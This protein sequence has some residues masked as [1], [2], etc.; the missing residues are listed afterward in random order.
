[1][2][3]LS[4]LFV[5]IS[6]EICH[7]ETGLK[8]RVLDEQGLPLPYASVLV[9][10]LNK[11]TSTNLDGYFFVKLENGS[12]TVHISS[13]GYQTLTL[14]FS[15]GPEL[16]DMGE[17]HL[18][19]AP[20][21]M[22][23]FV[24]SGSRIPEK[25][26][27]APA[28][29]D[30]IDGRQFEKFT[31]SPDELFALQKGVDFT[32]IG[33]F[34]ASMNVR[35]FNNAF[36]QKM[37]LLDDNRIA[38]VRIRTPVGPM[39]PYVKEDIERVELVLGPSSALYGPNCLNGLF[40]TISK[41]PFDRPGTDVVVG[42]GSN[43]L[44]NVR[45][46][47]A[48]KL[49]SKWAYK[50]TFE[51]LSGV[52]EEDYTDS[53]YIL[54]G[55]PPTVLRGYPEVGLDRDLLFLKGLAGVYY[56]PTEKS[57]L[58]INYTFTRNNSISVGNRNNLVDWYNASLQA[59]YKS[60]HWFVQFYKTWIN[61]GTS[62]NTV[63]RTTNYYQLL[64]SQTPDEAFN[65]SLNAPYAATFEDDTY[66][67]NGEIQYNNNWGNWSVTAGSQ[68]Q[69]EVAA[70][71]NTLYIGEPVRSNMLGVYGQ[72]MY[73]IAETGLKLLATA[74]GDDHSL[75]GFNFVP[76]A[77]ITY[78][79]N[80]ST[81]RLTYGEGSANPT[82]INS[83]I[84]L[85]VATGTTLGNSEG[86]TRSDGSKVAP[87]KPETLQTL[88]VGYKNIFY[89]R[90]LFVDIDAYYNWASN[91]I[92][93]V[94]SITTIGGPAIT[95]RGD[96]PIEDFVPP[97]TPIS[98]YINYGRANTYGLDIGLNYYLTD[99]YSL[100]LN[101]SFFEYIIDRSDANND[102][103]KD[104]IVNSQDIAPNTPENKISAA[105]NVKHNKFYGSL[106][107]RWIQK[108]DFFSG[109]SVA[110]STNPE[111]TYFLSPVVEGQR[112]GRSWNYG[113][114]GGFYL[115]F[116]GNYQITRRLNFG[117]YVNNILGQGNYEFVAA[118]ATETTFGAEIKVSF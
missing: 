49:S 117:L 40:N 18:I 58:G 104:G 4:F 110:A 29:I 82:L 53:V 39:S 86:F 109:R 87:I 54:T 57:E 17:I 38:N 97:K 114:L 34:M 108:Y 59:T 62:T 48:R 69:R 28:A 63:I 3:P 95:H 73:T 76:K 33:N 66:R 52:E 77:G 71:A 112:V 20:R 91:L 22:D 84:K 30:L 102:A 80:E 75:F 81:W 8:G 5:L 70:S 90:K 25:I 2:K 47:H 103:N 72:V 98:S 94:V 19:S 100:T 23:E 64:K 55:T 118:P 65:N 60:P 93:P 27:E 92:S 74:R 61:L 107:A 68:Y 85:P 6:L 1:M 37:L 35:G 44:L 26:T 7:G 83:Y 105:F 99:H 14:N 96:Q 31:G 45:L 16:T 113:P 79:R 15:I 51:Y 9:K 11:G 46:R 111:E 89:K 78:T 115:S 13:I 21:I 32:R 43:E 42:A 101:Y 50:V 88:E 10:P 36:N 12:Y 116:N 106:F 56:K 24:V 67:L 41:S